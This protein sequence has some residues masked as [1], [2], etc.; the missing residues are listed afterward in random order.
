MHVYKIV[1]GGDFNKNCNFYFTKLLMH[2]CKFLK[3]D[4]D[5]NGNLTVKLFL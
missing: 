3:R 5:G 2:G 4:L 1:H